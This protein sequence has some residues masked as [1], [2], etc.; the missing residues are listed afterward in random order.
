MNLNQLHS[1]DKLQ[2]A[3]KNEVIPPSDTRITEINIRKKLNKTNRIKRITLPAACIILSFLMGTTVLAFSS[4]WV[5]HNQGAKVFTITSLSEEQVVKSRDAETIDRQFRTEKRRIQQG[6]EPGQVAV[7]LAVESY[8]IDGRYSLLQREAIYDNQE[9][10]VTVLPKGFIL[11]AHT[12]D[13]L[14]FKKAS[15]EYAVND[16]VLEEIQEM[17]EEAKI[18]GQPTIYKKVDDGITN[19]IRIVLL[20]Y[21][22]GAASGAL[23]VEI[24]RSGGMI[25]TSEALVNNEIIPIQGIEAMYS[26]ENNQLL[27]VLPADDKF[28]EYHLTGMKPQAAWVSKE[29]LV[30][31]AHDIITQS[32]VTE[33]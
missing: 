19:E 10:L 32:M 9:Q 2:Q 18:K 25:S 14:Q 3:L 22:K 13:S 21:G 7:Y 8:E 5:L 6:L 28:L 31:L 30:E 33:Q 11:P 12:P 27:F 20:E 16:P 15:L 26:W 1:F 17:Y 23:Q 29:E 4:E 24:R